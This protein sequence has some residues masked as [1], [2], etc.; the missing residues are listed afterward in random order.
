[1]IDSRRDYRDFLAALVFGLFPFAAF[2]LGLFPFE[3]L[4]RPFVN[5]PTLL[6]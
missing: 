3:P 5:F 6:G 2:L 4:S 1:M